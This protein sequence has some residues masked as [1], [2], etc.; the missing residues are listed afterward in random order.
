V[1]AVEQIQV[2]EVLVDL[3]L[4]LVSLLSQETHIQ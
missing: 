2:V 3:E 1:V 4:A